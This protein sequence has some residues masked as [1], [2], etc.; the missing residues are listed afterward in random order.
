M[1]VTK[2]RQVNPAH[3]TITESPSGTMTDWWG[4]HLH[5]DLQVKL[6]RVDKRLVSHKCIIFVACSVVIF[7]S[8]P[9][10]VIEYCLNKSTG[11][12][13]NK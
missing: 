7:H 2:N 4:L 3:C 12:K 9:Y 5:W 13:N 11:R 6:F 1:N 8:K 10:Y